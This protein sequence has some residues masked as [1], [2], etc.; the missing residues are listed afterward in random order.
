MTLP[1]VCGAGDDVFVAVNFADK[2]A[3]NLK[4]AFPHE[5]IWKLRLNSDWSGYSADFGSEATDVT[6]KKEE[7]GLLAILKIPPYT[8]LI[9]SQDPAKHTKGE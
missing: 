8:A 6:A 4:V 9:Y 3:E 5:G 7:A 1:A 2:W